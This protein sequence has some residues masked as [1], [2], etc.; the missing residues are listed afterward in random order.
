MSVDNVREALVQTSTAYFYRAGT[1]GAE[2]WTLRGGI[3]YDF[4][5]RPSKILRNHRSPQ[6]FFAASRKDC[7]LDHS[8]R[9]GV[10]YFPPNAAPGSG[11]AHGSDHAAGC[12]ELELA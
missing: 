9:R 10:G 5:A 11:P 4:A 1:C 3:L 12:A 2:L 8:K 7:C 6:A